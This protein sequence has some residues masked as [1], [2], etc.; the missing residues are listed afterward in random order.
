MMELGEKVSRVG[1][2]MS[3]A[4]TLPLVALGRMVLQNEKVQQSIEPLKQKWQELSDKLATSLLP[5]IDQLVPSIMK[6][7]DTISGWIDQ[8]NALD[9]STKTTIVAVLGVIAAIGPLLT[10]IGQAI[11]FVG[12]LGSIWTTLSGILAPLISTVIPAIG[13]VITAVGLPVIALVAAIGLL[14]AVIIIFGKQ[15]WQTILTIG[16]IF[17]VLFEAAKINVEKAI[18]FLRDTDWGAVGK[19]ILDKIGEGIKNGVSAIIT[20]AKNAAQS[21]LNAAISFL[22]GGGGGSGGGKTS[23]PKHAIGG[24]ALGGIP[25]IVGEVGPEMIIPATDSYVIPNKRMGGMGGQNVNLTLV[26]SPTVSFASQEE[27]NRVILPMVRKA[28]RYA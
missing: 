22:S 18:N 15:A 1:L 26:Y 16:D 17:R 8:F 6:V 14:V 24:L 13:A 2:R 19:A 7:M 28:L 12:T 10:I 4:F 23:P 11:A 9:P 5:V 25:A 21:A 20:A 27:A 3:A